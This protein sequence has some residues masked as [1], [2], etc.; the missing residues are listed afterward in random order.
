MSKRRLPTKKKPVKRQ[1]AA[2]KPKKHAKRLSYA[3][4]AAA[5]KGWETRRERALE[6]AEREAIQHEGPLLEA[7]R[8][9]MS[10]HTRGFFGLGS[11]S[12]LAAL[13]GRSEST[14]RRWKKEGIPEKALRL[15]EPHLDQHDS[16]YVV[17]RLAFENL[18]KAGLWPADYYIRAAIKK[19]S[20]GQLRLSSVATEQ[21]IRDL[22]SDFDY[23]N[24]EYGD[25]YGWD[26]HDE[27]GDDY[28]NPFWYHD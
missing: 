23:Y 2:S 4:S 21:E 24:D 3:R 22:A 16:L 15:V 1:K 20:V 13:V 14:I 27:Y 28:E 5:K 11:P 10:R 12:K 25:E 9:S 17:R 18:K 26:D 6:R 7:K 8:K 19:M